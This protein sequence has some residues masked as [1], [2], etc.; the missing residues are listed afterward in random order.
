VVAL[1]SQQLNINAPSHCD[2]LAEADA[3]QP[4]Q[5][6]SPSYTPTF[7]SRPY[8]AGNTSL[9]TY[10]SMSPSDASSTLASPSPSS[11]IIDL[12]YRH[13]LGDSGY[14]NEPSPTNLSFTTRDARQ[15][16]FAQEK[17]QE[18]WNEGPS[19]QQQLGLTGLQR[20]EQ[21]HDR[22][23]SPSMATPKKTATAADSV[24]VATYSA[25]S[26]PQIEHGHY[27]VHSNVYTSSPKG[28]PSSTKKA[29]LVSGFRKKLGFNKE[30][31]AATVIASK[32]WNGSRSSVIDDTNVSSPSTSFKTITGSGSSH[33]DPSPLQPT[34]IKL[35]A[36]HSDQSVPRLQKETLTHSRTRS[37]VVLSQSRPP[38][39][40]SLIEHTSFD[41]VRRQ[42]SFNSSASIH[43]QNQ[44]GH[45]DQEG[46]VGANEEETEELQMDDDQ[47]MSASLHYSMSQSS[48]NSRN[49]RLQSPIRPIRQSGDYSPTKSQFGPLSIRS[50]VENNFNAAHDQR[51]SNIGPSFQSDKRRGSNSSALGVEQH[52]S[53]RGSISSQ[54][55]QRGSWQ[56]IM[57]VDVVGLV[58]NGSLASRRGSNGST[59]VSTLLSTRRD[60]NGSK[61]STLLPSA[62]RDSNGSKGPTLLQ[63]TRRGSNGNKTSAFGQVSARLSSAI[64]SNNHSRNKSL[65]GAQ[66]SRPTT[67]I[68]GSSAILTDETAVGQEFG[69]QE[70]NVVRRLKSNGDMRMRP[71][72]AAPSPLSSY[73]NRSSSSHSRLNSRRELQSAAGR[74]ENFGGSAWHDQQV[75]NSL[76]GQFARFSIQGN[77]AQEVPTPKRPTFGLDMLADAAAVFDCIPSPVPWRERTP[78]VSTLLEL[79]ASD[80]R[81]VKSDESDDDVAAAPSHNDAGDEEFPN[82]PDTEEEGTGQELVIIA[83]EEQQHDFHS[84]GRFPC[85][86]P[87]SPILESPSMGELDLY[88]DDEDFQLRRESIEE[89]P[90]APPM[91]MSHPPIASQN[92]LYL[93]GM[94]S[95]TDTY[96][97]GR[98][99]SY[100]FI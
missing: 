1:K 43:S 53:E 9:L 33:R 34:R 88:G 83:E 78:S 93:T 90:Y 94:V 84:E 48:S 63:S 51:W 74:V 31:K 7:S 58:R 65:N 71:G 29:S 15:T 70:S 2:S 35:L 30:P 23:L 59:K 42:Q 72:T 56:S 73:V 12:Q 89:S 92:G 79:S 16:Y 68:G 66:I 26:S 97:G 85:D 21:Y 99:S 24:R 64:S 25:Q 6:F 14:S 18:A 44:Q 5:P 67:V 40:D 77:H 98:R 27:P 19:V 8:S 49:G 17:L 96:N 82:T 57:G 22:S 20:H 61:G 54:T 69:S 50:E 80:L 55:K 10:G 13:R 60:S 47:P 41:Q 76:Q 91:G 38:S 28:S 100:S 75:D 87:E 95:P 36:R 45:R 62:R 37:T 3:R 52:P 11:H 81:N 4:F 46:P 39:R 86:A 32:S